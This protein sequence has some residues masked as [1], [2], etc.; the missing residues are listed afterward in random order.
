MIL[1]LFHT[2]KYTYAVKLEGE[3][4]RYEKHYV[5]NKTPYNGQWAAYY[6]LKKI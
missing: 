3:V 4:D 2:L 6:I 1:D 5:Q